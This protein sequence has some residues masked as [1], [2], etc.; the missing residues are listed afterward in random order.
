MYL[1]LLN[2]NDNISS[3]TSSDC[4]IQS[5]QKFWERMKIL[6]HSPTVVDLAKVL[7][8]KRST[9]SSWI[10]ADRRPPMHVLLRLSQLTGLGLEELEFGYTKGYRED[11]DVY[12][13]PKDRKQE[14]LS[15]IEQFDER[16]LDFIWCFLTSYKNCIATDR[17]K[18]VY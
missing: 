7:G 9:L 13:R 18:K 14:I 6:L 17:E 3:F 4:Y 2:F 5:M 12:E 16:E 15:L 10:H 11:E 8:V 1:K